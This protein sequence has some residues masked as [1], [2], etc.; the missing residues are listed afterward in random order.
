MCRVIRARRDNALPTVVRSSSLARRAAF[1][2]VLCALAQNVVSAQASGLLRALPGWPV[3]AMPAVLSQMY[4][5]APADDTRLVVVEETFRGALRGLDTDSIDAA[6]AAVRALP[7]TIPRQVS[8][9]GNDDKGIL[10]F[11][12][13]AFQLLGPRA[14]SVPM[15]YLV[16][17]AVSAL[18]LSLARRQDPVT[19]AMGALVLSCHAA[20][21]PYLAAYGQL[22]GFLALRFMPAMALLACLQLVC[23]SLDARPT[24]LRVAGWV[25]QAAIVAATVQIRTSAAWLLVAVVAAAIARVSLHASSAPRASASSPTS[26]PSA[27]STGSP[28]QALASASRPWVLV[29]AIA[30][31]LVCV[32]LTW[33]FATARSARAHPGYA[34]GEQIH[35]HVFWHSVLSGLAFSRQLADAWQIRLDDVSV[36]AATGRFLTERGE[37]DRWS[38]VEGPGAAYSTVRWAPYDVAVR[39]LVVDI[40]LEDP[41]ACA[42]SLL[43][44]KP[45]ALI[46]NVAWV[47]GLREALPRPELLDETVSRE[48]ALARDHLDRIGFSGPLSTWTLIVAASALI[49]AAWAGPLVDARRDRTGLALAILWAASAVPSLVAYPA[50]HVVGE[51]VV[52]S[53]TLLL[54]TPALLVAR[55]RAWIWRWRAS[56]SACEAESVGRVG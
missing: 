19:V 25:A 49:L 51:P 14:V 18:L 35:G 8:L 44:E 38:A 37:S 12:W 2:L 33:G 55:G 50:P 48:V 42:D 30:P 34:A 20:L 53:W 52:L 1:L 27:V 45:A 6:I 3:D 43:I 24:P 21:L 47:S 7:P 40:C 36:I 4:F 56:R 54:A 46:G 22:G 39:E 28:A 16:V 31:A 10:D 32:S 11:V 15:L 23:D 26:L 29:C 13:L 41:L 5:D 17:V 9:L